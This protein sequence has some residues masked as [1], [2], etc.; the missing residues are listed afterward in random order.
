M[1]RRGTPFTLQTT[2]VFSVLVTVTSSCS[3]LPNRTL[4][5]RRRDGNR[6]GWGRWWGRARACASPCTARKRK[7]DCQETEQWPAGRCFDL[8]MVVQGGATCWLKCRR[9]ARRRQR[10]S[11]RRTSHREEAKE[12]SLTVAGQ[13][14]PDLVCQ[15]REKIP[16]RNLVRFRCSPPIGLYFRAGVAHLFCDRT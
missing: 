4:L 10:R 11:E 1:G 7:G 15:L 9:S 3:V 13:V 16:I 6:N 12:G 14:V 5:G 8:R 2:P